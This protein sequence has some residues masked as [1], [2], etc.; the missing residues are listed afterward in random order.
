MAKKSTPKPLG[1]ILETYIKALGHEDKYL[2]AKIVNNW[3]EIVGKAVANNTQELFV[4]NKVLYVKVESSI[5]KHELNFI[6]S[7]LIDKINK[8]LEKNIIQNV[9]IY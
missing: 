5:L 9:V 3:D 1:N 8:Y 7:G 4:E 6:K 2:A